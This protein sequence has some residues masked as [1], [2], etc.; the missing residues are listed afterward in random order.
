MKTALKTALLATALAWTVLSGGSVFAAE[1][2]IGTAVYD[3]KPQRQVVEIG[4]REGQFKGIRFDVRG[5]DI[6]VQ[7]V[8]I[9]YGNGEPEDLNVR[10]TF[11]AGS[12][13]RVFDLK[14]YKRAIKQIVII[15][16]ARAPATIRIF[17]IEG[18]APAPSWERLGCKEVR[19]GI[20]HDTLTVGRKDGTFK[21]IKL[22]VRF[23][24]VEFFDVR[25]VFG[26]G[27]RQSVTVRQVIPP[28]GETRVI[29]LSGDNRGLDRVELLYRSIPSFKG[30]AEVCVSALQR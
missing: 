10:Q 1:K 4:A 23:A 12:S 18:A 16:V 11:K 7:G 27:Q 2:L 15:Y 13:S 26:N 22:S 28:G 17:G 19:F 20:D 29:D 9:V 21:A 3:V 14:G 25:V 8:R 5:S 30:A 6:E 24:P